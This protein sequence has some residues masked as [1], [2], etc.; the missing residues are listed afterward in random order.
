MNVADEYRALVR[1]QTREQFAAAYPF[2][3]LVGVSRLNRPNQPG[4]T[5]M[6]DSPE[7]RQAALAPRP[8]R[9]TGDV[10]LVLPVRKVQPAFP[11]MITVGRTAN[12]DVV[13]E[14]V[15]VSKFHAFFRAQATSLELA[16]AGSRNGTFIGRARLESKGPARPVRVG[17][18]IRF[19]QVEF[20]FLDAAGLYD[21]LR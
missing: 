10:L 11:S 3:F 5:M 12:N 2:H 4:R 15:Q 9:Q 18:T 14:D 16:D 20:V 21:R 6:L 19:G 13:V 7:A 8:R 17:D 1:A